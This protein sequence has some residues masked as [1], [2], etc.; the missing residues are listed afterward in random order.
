MVGEGMAELSAGCCKCVVES[1]AWI[2]HLIHS[3][4]SFQATFIETGIVG[5]EGNGGYLVP[6]VICILHIREEYINDPFLQQLPDF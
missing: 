6:D 1:V 5:Y 2:V 3:E 4:N